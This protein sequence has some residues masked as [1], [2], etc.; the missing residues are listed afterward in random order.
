MGG[1]VPHL[2]QISPGFTDC[3]GTRAKG[4]FKV[5]T[6]AA[7]QAASNSVLAVTPVSLGKGIWVI[8]KKSACS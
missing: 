2:L 8:P 1:L 5:D 3:P 4:H 7:K 6:I